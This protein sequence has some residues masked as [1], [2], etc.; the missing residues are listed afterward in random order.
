[1]ES[2]NTKPRPRI[3]S[4]RLRGEPVEKRHAAQMAK[5]LND[6]VMYRFLAEEPPSLEK[7]ERQYEFLSGGKS[8]DGLE[9]WLTWILFS[10][11]GEG[12]PLGFVQ[13]TIREPETVHIA[14]VVT[15][16]N[17]RRGYAKEAISG[18][19][20]V[21]FENYRVQ[22]AIAE[23]DTRNDASIGL[24]RSLG[25]DH[26]RTVQDVAEFKGSTSHEYEYEITHD[27]WRTQ[28]TLAA[29]NAKAS[30]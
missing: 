3:D 25:F 21:V 23:M 9:Y 6:A 5:V 18:L 17:W 1:M 15:R 26:V 24:I 13:A 22:K 10:K 30:R 27:H 8:P 16:P 2:S 14:Y 7:L 12:D 29:R 19:L 11:H 4:A 28:R 20:D